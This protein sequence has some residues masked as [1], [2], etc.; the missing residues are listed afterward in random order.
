MKLLASTILLLLSI[1]ISKAQDTFEPTV[2]ILY[3]NEVVANDSINR[4]HDVYV[5]ELEITDALQKNYVKPGLAKNWKIIR[6]K[7]L[8]F[9]KK[10]DFATLLTFTLSHE[11]TYKEL[12]HHENL[13]IFPV[14]ESTN[15]RLLYKSIAQKYKVVW[16]VNILKVE[17]SSVKTIKKMKVS[18]QM[19]NLIANRLM[20]DT[21]YTAD[22]TTTP[23]SCDPGSWLCLVESI[24]IPIAKDLED[25]IEKNSHTYGK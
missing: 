18:V 11:I 8:E 1:Q 16:V 12:P 5:K 7:E 4:E 20:L 10:Q 19:Y 9:I 15:N 13:L 6:E 21:S 25:R 23:E 17:L 3:P 2:V 24:K 14:K 22:D